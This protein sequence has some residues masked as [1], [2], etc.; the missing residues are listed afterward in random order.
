MASDPTVSRDGRELG[1]GGK[2]A[3]ADLW[4]LEEYAVERKAFRA[5]VIAHKKLRRV[6][7]GPHATLLFEDFLTMKYQVQEMLRIERIFE[8]AAIDEE[9]A[10]YNPLIPDGSN[11][12]ATFLIEYADPEER[13]LALARMPGVEHRVWFRIG[14]GERNFA[15]ANDDMERTERDKTAAVHFLRFELTKESAEAVRSGE[16][17][18]IGIDHPELLSETPLS[19]STVASLAEDLDRTT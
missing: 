11:W 10:A 6:A 12:K 16:E 14:A 5:R 18:R 4:R 17:V 8:P 15:H 19:A 1:H 3:R 2:L 13:A 7:L 9:L